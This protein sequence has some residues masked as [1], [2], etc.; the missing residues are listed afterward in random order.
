FMTSVNG[1]GERTGNA[2][3]HQ[4]LMQLRYLF[5]VEVPDFA[6]DGV[7][8]LARLVE[9]LSGIPVPPTEPGIGRNVFRHESGIHTAGMLIHPSLYQFIPP[10]DWG[11]EI[12]SVSGKP[13][14]AQ[15]A[16]HAVRLAGV[17]CTAE[18]VERVTAEVKR[19]REERAVFD[20]PGRFQDHYERHLDGL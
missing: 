12:E 13:P 11:P 20:P 19:I 1:L 4:V 9:R 2:P 15:V 16:E 3:L 5:D 17:E 10:Q 8:R 14:G 18:L 7:R 6:Y